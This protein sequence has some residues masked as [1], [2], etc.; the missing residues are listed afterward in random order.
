MRRELI[1]SA[2]GDSG[3]RCCINDIAVQSVFA[4]VSETIQILTLFK[5]R[6]G[7]LHSV[8]KDERFSIEA[9]MPLWN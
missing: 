5:I 1:Q 8:R 6:F 7:L 4:S 9:T 3:L 2:D